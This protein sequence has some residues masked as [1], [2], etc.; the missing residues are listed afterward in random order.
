MEVDLESIDQDLDET[1]FAPLAE[2]AEKAAWSVRRPFGTRSSQS[3][4]EVTGKQQQVKVSCADAV[5][6]PLIWCALLLVVSLD[7]R[8][9]AQ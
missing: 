3:E 1:F 5:S 8:D 6:D 9:C 2:Q 4:V 7:D